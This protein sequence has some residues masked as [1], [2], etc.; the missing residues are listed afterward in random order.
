MG[1]DSYVEESIGLFRSPPHLQIPI[2]KRYRVAVGVDLVFS[3]PKNNAVMVSTTSGKPICITVYGYCEK[4][5]ALGA[6]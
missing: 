4:T 6:Q 3:D 5:R 1:L 2:G